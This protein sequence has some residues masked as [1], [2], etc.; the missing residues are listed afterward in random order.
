MAPALTLSADPEVPSTAKILA[1]A[2]VAGVSIQLANEKATTPCGLPIPTLK[3]QDGG[4]IKHTNAILRRLACTSPD[5]G[6]LGTSF[7]EES[8]IDSWLEWGALE[9]DH[10]M[11]EGSPVAPLCA[12]LE[13]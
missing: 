5:T 7:F 3:T 9:V 10:T 8:A 13:P 1:T 2:R 4:I 12:V 6:L 11:L